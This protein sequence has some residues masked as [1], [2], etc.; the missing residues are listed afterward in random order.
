MQLEPMLTTAAGLSSQHSQLFEKAKEME[1]LFLAEMLSHAGLGNP[2]QQFGGGIGE[3]QF[4]SFLR[5]AQARNMVEKGG[6]GLAQT[7][8]ASLVKSEE[9]RH[10]R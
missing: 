3:E 2:S 9:A 6:L 4:S 7:I 5:N 1:V 8:F 10:A